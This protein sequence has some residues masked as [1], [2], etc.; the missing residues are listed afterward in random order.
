ML[1]KR[2]ILMVIGVIVA[3]LIT[4]YTNAFGT[5][6][7]RVNIAPSTDAGSTNMFSYNGDAAVG[8]EDAPGSAASDLLHFLLHSTKHSVEATLQIGR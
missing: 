7:I 6:P 2:K 4:F 1:T 8:I 5:G 3:V